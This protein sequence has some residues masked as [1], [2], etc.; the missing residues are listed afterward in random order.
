[1]A[2]HTVDMREFRL[3]LDNK[4]TTNNESRPV[5]KELPSPV[6]AVRGCRFG[7][8][9]PPAQ[10]IFSGLLLTLKDPTTTALAWGKFLDKTFGQ[11][12]NRGIDPEHSLTLLFPSNPVLSPRTVGAAFSRL[13]MLDLCGIPELAKSGTTLLR[14]GWAKSDKSPVTLQ[15]MEAMREASRDLLQ[16]PS[17]VSA[18][19]TDQTSTRSHKTVSTWDLPEPLK[20]TPSDLIT[21][22]THSW[23]RLTP[24]DE[25]LVPFT[26]LEPIE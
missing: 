17:D 11:D 8:L 9:T 23:D 4:L 18:A 15:L 22:K 7:D 2:R 5:A 1:M 16:L 6:F 24:G 3:F 10:E 21:G 25:G 14:T 20:I 12:L 19:L 26:L 13:R